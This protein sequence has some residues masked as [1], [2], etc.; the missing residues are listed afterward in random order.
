MTSGQYEEW[1]DKNIPGL[2]FPGMDRLNIRSNRNN[3]IHTDAFPIPVHIDMYF[4]W[5][6][7]ELINMELSEASA[8]F[9]RTRTNNII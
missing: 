8:T 4:H 1:P 9:R 5:L 7:I 2:S 3:M 6:L